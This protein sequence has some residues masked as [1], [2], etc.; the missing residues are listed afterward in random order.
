MFDIIIFATALYALTTETV[1]D[2]FVLVIYQIM[3]GK[4]NV[5]YG[6]VSAAMTISF[7][8]VIL[9]LYG[10]P[11]LG[12]YSSY[13]INGSG[14]FLIGLGIYWI[15]RFWLV[16]RGIMQEEA[17]RDSVETSVSKSFMSFMMVFVEL[18]EILAILI[19]FTLANYIV[20]VSLSS[21]ISIAA[22]LGLVF[23]VGGKMRRKLENRLTQVKLFAGIALILSGVVIITNIK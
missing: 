3:F 2:A 9:V 11:N 13:V 5:L 22:S 23:A 7:I 1:E 19:P 20:E 21:A 10:I 12:L 6:L 16:K 14:I 4:K 8:M 15:L 17:N 18:L